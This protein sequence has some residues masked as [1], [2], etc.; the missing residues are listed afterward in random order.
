MNLEAKL[1]L[2]TILT[3]ANLAE[4]LSD[5]DLATISAY[6]SAGFEADMNS[7]LDWE[8]K[9]SDAMK[10]ALQVKEEK[11][12]PWQGCSNVKFPLITI[13]AIQ[14]H[15]RAY[16]ALIQAPSVVLCQAYGSDPEGM[17]AKSSAL[18]SEHMSWQVLEED[19]QW[20]EE[21]DRALL[22]QPILG[23][24]FKK[25]YFDPVKKHNVSETLLPSEFVVNYWTKSLETSP[26]MS[27]IQYHFSNKF[28]EN[29]TRGIWRDLQPQIDPIAPNKLG[30][31]AQARDEAQGAYASQNDYDQPV[32]VIEQCCFLDLDGD[33]YREPYTVTFRHDNNELLRIVARFTELDVETNPKGDII[34]ICPE[35][36]YTKIPFI[37]SPDGGFYDLGFGVL[38]GPINSSIDSSINQLIDAG[39]MSN[40]GGGFLGRGVRV[41]GGNYSF[42]PNEWKRVDSTGDDLRQNIFPL[43]VRE[44]SQV[45]LQL[46]TLL[47][48]YGEKVTGATEAVSGEN[49]GQNTKSGTMDS[50]LE[51]GL[52]I[53]SG[54][55]KRTWRA[56][57]DEYRK[58]FKLNKL[59]LNDSTSFSSMLDGAEKKILI[60][61]Y[62]LP[63]TAIRPAADPNYMSDRQRMEQARTVRMASLEKPIYNNLELERWFL[64]VMKVPN[65][66]KILV[67]EEPQPS[68]PH[69]V[70]VAQIKAQQAE[71]Q[72]Q[73]DREEMMNDFKLA[74]L[75]LSNDADK[76]QAEIVN[77]QA[78]AL[79]YT[80][81]A[82]TAKQDA[83][84][85][86]I[87]AQIG[88]AKLHHD[89]ILKSIDLMGKTIERQQK[90]KEKKND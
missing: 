34:K 64:E 59:F 74:L 54:I 6:C 63:E 25:S 47:I 50:M 67:K 61:A 26:R 69:Q 71:A 76:T 2:E 11:N 65:I 75:E 78:Q 29:I 86:V 24:V 52:K 90:L 4:K 89:V 45:L 48:Q 85:S 35:N 88:A 37:P 55:Y 27:H 70:Q 58:L 30:P 17:K 15:S 79:L 23:S 84:I 41:K 40:A 19:R 9:M 60:E 12:F 46:L 5:P 21:T 10:L 43:P 33:G 72:L 66:D 62:N 22:C 28:H 77:L 49:V 13:A 39:T 14:Y 51:Q 42:T 73:K 32:I 3:T 18:V 82:G 1:S 38:L 20:E 36:P 16:P 68:P 31:L 83:D 81:Q 53:F 80:E 7:R 56:F 8:V 57:R 87:N 44:P